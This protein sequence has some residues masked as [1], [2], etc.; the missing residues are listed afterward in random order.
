MEGLYQEDA[1]QP[2][3]VPDEEEG[4][5]T[6]KQQVV[7]QVEQVLCPFPFLCLFLYLYPAVGEEEVQPAAEPNEEEGDD[8][9]EQEQERNPHCLHLAAVV[10][11]VVV[12]VQADPCASYEHDGE[13]DGEQGY[14]KSIGRVHFV[15]QQFGFIEE[16][17]MV[18]PWKMNK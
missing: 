8:T 1:K 18:I 2:I 6:L 13:C 16:Y 9:E 14:P 10:V 4:D 12:A 7:D 17:L 15:V 11:V 3:A 5:Y